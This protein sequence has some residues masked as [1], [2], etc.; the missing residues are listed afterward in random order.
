MLVIVGAS[1]PAFVPAGAPCP[2]SRRLGAPACSLKPVGCSAAG[3]ALASALALAGANGCFGILDQTEDELA[4]ILGVDEVSPA[5]T[6]AVLAARPVYES[7]KTVT[8]SCTDAVFPEFNSVNDFNDCLLL[9]TRVFWRGLKP[10]IVIDQTMQM[11]TIAKQSTGS[12]VWGGGVV[13]ARYMEELGGDFWGGKQVIELGSGAG[14]GS[15]TAAKLGAQNVLATDRDADVLEL[16]K[17]NL[18]K[19]LG[20]RQTSV[21][22]ARLDW[23]QASEVVDRTQWD[24]A[25]GA[26]LT[27]NRCAPNASQ[28]LQPSKAGAPR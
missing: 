13:L 19:N 18:A 8:P 2:A 26:D 16:I 28:H 17:V 24:V 21:A 10:P 20:E 4:D 11:S 3:V 12:S 1:L 23:G 27:Y 6:S 25:I 7:F 14:L 22:V 5:L 15:V 9:K